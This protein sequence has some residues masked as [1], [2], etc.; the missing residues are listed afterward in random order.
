M[1]NE[2]GNGPLDK[3]YQHSGIEIIPAEEAYNKGFNDGVEWTMDKLPKWRESSKEY[4][5]DK[6]KVYEGFGQFKLFWKD[7]VI[8][9]NKV[10]ETLPKK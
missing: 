4:Y 2:L 1:T 3:N 8:D 10:F 5:T 7:R 9:L 6:P